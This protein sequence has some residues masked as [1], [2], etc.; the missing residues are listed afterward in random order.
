MWQLGA[1]SYADTYDGKLIIYLPH[2]SKQILATQAEELSHFETVQ[3][4]L[5]RFLFFVTPTT[6]RSKENHYAIF[7]TLLSAAVLSGLET[8]AILTVPSRL[9]LTDIHIQTSVL[10]LLFP[11]LP[12]QFSFYLR[13]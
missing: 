13:R 4:F 5:Q 12:L 8:Y 1:Y 7:K 2:T 10:A 11:S 9:W 6:Q 3:R